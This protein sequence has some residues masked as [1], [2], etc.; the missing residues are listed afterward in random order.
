MPCFASFL[1][2][3][4]AA[5]N[6]SRLHCTFLDEVRAAGGEGSVRHYGTDVEDCTWF[7]RYRVRCVTLSM[8]FFRLAILGL[9]CLKTFI[10]LSL[11]SVSAASS[12]W[13]LFS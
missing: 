9:C 6:L 8:A 4:R 10:K 3:K 5:V 12:F 7:S 2:S 13:I 11:G 1:V